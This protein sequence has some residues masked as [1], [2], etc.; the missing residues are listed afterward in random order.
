VLA[1]IGKRWLDARDDAG[2]RRLDDPHDWVRLEIGRALKRGVTVIPVR[3]EGAE[4]PKK[5]ALPRDI[6]GL[7]D[8]QAIN[9]TSTSFRND[10]A[11]LS[12]DIR[13]ISSPKLIGMVTARLG[14]WSVRTVAILAVLAVLLGS[15]ALYQ[16][17]QSKYWTSWMN[18]A[19][20]QQEF[21]SQ[22]KN[23]W[24]PSQIEAGAIGSVVK[25]RG[26]FEPFPNANFQFYSKHSLNDE[27]FSAADA[28]FIQ[29][30][31]KR[32]FQQRIVIDARPYN[33]GTWIKP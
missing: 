19:D 31:F 27:E 20:Y 26:H 10:M 9:V 16:H 17:F 14:Q 29:K 30:G 13:A 33:Q 18:W 3:I 8:H 7:V 2:N 21:N 25:Y 11:G 6:E 1:L 4:L 32:V 23:Q 24:Y 15:Y 12:R 22:L 5:S 28:E